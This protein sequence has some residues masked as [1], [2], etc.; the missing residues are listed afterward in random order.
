MLAMG[1]S[2]GASVWIQDKSIIQ[3]KGNCYNDS[4]PLPIFLIVVFCCLRLNLPMHIRR[5]EEQSQKK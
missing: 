1:D 2:L 4:C 3:R 5:L